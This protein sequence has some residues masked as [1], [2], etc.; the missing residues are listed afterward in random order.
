[1]VFTNL[2]GCVILKALSIKTKAHGLVNVLCK[3]NSIFM[4]S[5]FLEKKPIKP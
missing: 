5:E 1:M 4:N 3:G 2:F